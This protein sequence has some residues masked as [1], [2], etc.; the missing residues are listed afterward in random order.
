MAEAA[1]VIK[2]VST[3]SPIGETAV[4]DEAFAR[5]EDVAEE[6]TTAGHTDRSL[7]ST[8]AAQ[9]KALDR[10]REQLAKLLRDIEVSGHSVS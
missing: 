7:V 5:L 3:K 4:T 6:A 9:L 8:L 1:S 2:H 10:Q